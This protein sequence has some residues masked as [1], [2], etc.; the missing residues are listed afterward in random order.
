MEGW[1]KTWLGMPN[2]THVEAQKSQE[3]V[4]PP[5]IDYSQRYFFRHW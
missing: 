1:N 5:K 2:I 4:N 3:V